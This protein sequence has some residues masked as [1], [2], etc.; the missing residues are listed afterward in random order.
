MT[1]YFLT[2]EEYDLQYQGLK[3]DLK[4]YLSEIKKAKSILEIGCGTGR[5]LLPALKAGADISGLDFSKKMLKTLHQKAK[6]MGLKP[7][8]YYADMRN[9]SLG[10]K[11]KLIIAPFRPF[12]HLYNTNEQITALKNF[13]K[14]LN[15]GGKLILNVFNP[16]Y[17]RMTRSGQKEFYAYVRDPRTKNKVKITAINY[18]YPAE[19]LLKVIFIHEELDRH[20]LLVGKKEFKSVLR[21]F[22]RF[23]FEH[24]LALTGF[25]PLKLYGDFKRGKFTDKS[26]EMV[27]V[28][29]KA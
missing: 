6:R 9:F 26:R 2:G 27:W 12:Q 15:K 11:Y 24:L 21:Y 5:I 22:F 23:E 4:F 3:V 20:N 1:P 28:C 29:A 14:H 8:T 13:H 7:I 17:L 25:K 10:E 18:Y 19:Q 16:D